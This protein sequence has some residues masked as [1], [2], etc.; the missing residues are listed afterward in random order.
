MEEL[1]KMEIEIL[2]GSEHEPRWIQADQENDLFRSAFLQAESALAEICNITDK[3]ERTKDKMQDENLLYC[4]GNN[5]IAFCG[6]R[7][8]GKTSAMLSFARNLSKHEKYR[9]NMLIL[10]TIDPTMLEP[11]DSILNVVLA[12]MFQKVQE[13]WKEDISFG[14]KKGDSIRQELTECFQLCMEGVAECNTRK[15]KWPDEF[16]SLDQ[17]EKIGD[18]ARL[19]KNILDLVKNI[20]KFSGH[21][22][23]KGYLV[24]ALDD[25][26]LQFQ[27]AYNIMEDIRKYLSI[28]HVVVLMALHLEQMRDLVEKQYHTYFPKLIDDHKIRLRASRY[29][30][31]MFPASHVVFL[32]QFEHFCRDSHRTLEL[33]YGDIIQKKPLQEGVLNYIHRKTGLIFLVPSSYLHNM[34]PTNLRGLSQLLNLL[35]NMKDIPESTYRTA[36]LTKESVKD[37]HK[38]AGVALRN[39]HVFESYFLH[40][41]CVEEL[42]PQHSALLE[43]VCQVALSIQIPKLY[44]DIRIMYGSL[45]HQEDNNRE[46]Q[47]NGITEEE[48][49]IDENDGETSYSRLVILLDSIAKKRDAEIYRFCFA[50]HTYLM[51]QLHKS[52]WWTREDA[53]LGTNDKPSSIIEYQC[54]EDL[55]EGT[56]LLQ[57]RDGKYANDD[58]IKCQRDIS[59]LDGAADREKVPYTLLARLRGNKYYYD[60]TRPLFGALSKEIGKLGNPEDS[61]KEMIYGWQEASLMIILNWD[62]QE[63]MRNLDVLKNTI[64]FPTNIY[65][66]LKL[67]LTQKKVDEIIK[68]DKKNDDAD[69]SNILDRILNLWDS[70]RNSKVYKGFFGYKEIENNNRDDADILSEDNEDLTSDPSTKSPKASGQKK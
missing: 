66:G 2:P 27:S 46:K 44:H 7:G 14:S 20:I 1:N 41:W 26:D 30:A 50:V 58:F 35:S 5:R 12:R 69:I 29:I 23:E 22:T 68:K 51:L 3:Y 56:L 47:N 59:S 42:T 70:L 38:R 6:K 10:P 52:M 48:N 21:S 60:Y 16:S 64:D 28:P 63:Q 15:E 65:D 40:E 53:D 45:I 32:P 61:R 43:D 25:T 34:I 24:I 19:K 17:L 62:I 13:I 57:P 36:F 54:L 4:F 9:E 49:I 67:R 39:L 33:S 11:K 8:Q 55:L 37:M 31:K 18:S